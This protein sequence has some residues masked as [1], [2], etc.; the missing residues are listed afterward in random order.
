MYLTLD[1][2]DGQEGTNEDIVYKFPSENNKLTEIRGL[3]LTL[4]G[5]APDVTGDAVRR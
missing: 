4:C 1:T 2:P 3:F 5:V